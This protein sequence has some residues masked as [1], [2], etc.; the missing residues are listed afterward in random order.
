MPAWSASDEELAAVLT[1]I[2]R[3]WGHG[4]EPL[5][6]E[7]VSALRAALPTRTRPWTVPELE[8]LP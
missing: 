4:A 7:R 6:S 5:D 8:A 3:E 2:R 1:Y